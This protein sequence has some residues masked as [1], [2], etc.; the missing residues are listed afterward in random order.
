VPCA[1]NRCSQN[2]ETLGLANVSLTRATVRRAFRMAAR[3]WHPD[4]FEN[5]EAKR[6]EAEEVFKRIQVAYRELWEHVETPVLLESDLTTQRARGKTAGPQIPS[7][8]FGS[9]PGCYTAPNLPRYLSQHLIG[10]MH[11]GES[12]LAVVEISRRNP[13]SGTPPEFVLFTSYRIIVRSALSLVSMLWYTDLGDIKL[14]DRRQTG[15]RNLWQRIVDDISDVKD[16]CTLE[17]YRRE[18]TLFY[19]FRE[20]ANDSMKKVVY[21]FLRQ[22]KA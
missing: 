17:I 10:L 18:G 6:I 4:R 19:T 1:C 16:T 8:S 3:K 2:A 22:M 5:D 15:K 21:N 12:P 9:I 7:I 13:L 14:E 20:S 11:E